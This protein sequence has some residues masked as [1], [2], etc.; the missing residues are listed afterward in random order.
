MTKIQF[1]LSEKPSKAEKQAK[2][3]S[4]FVVVKVRWVIERSNS[5]MEIRVKAIALRD[6][7]LRNAKDYEIFEEAKAQKAIVMTKDSDFLT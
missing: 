2:G 5:W 7:G 4:G 6:L 3:I 1:E